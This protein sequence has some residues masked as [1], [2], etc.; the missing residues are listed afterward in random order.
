M[1]DRLLNLEQWFEKE[2]EVAEK[3]LFAEDERVQNIE[4]QV[5]TIAGKVDS[6]L[7]RAATRVTARE[8][9]AAERLERIEDSVDKL[10]CTVRNACNFL[11][12]CPDGLEKQLPGKPKI[13]PLPEV[14]VNVHGRPLEDWNPPLTYLRRSPP[15]MPRPPR[16]PVVEK[17]YTAATAWDVSPPPASIRSPSV[18]I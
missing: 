6:V 18:P 15:G 3:R 9:R 11:G 12:L 8:A 10:A 1:K 14:P 13:S 16:P 2:V 4:L 5:R 7:R 17:I